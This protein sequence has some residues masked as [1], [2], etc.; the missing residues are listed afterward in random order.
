MSVCCALSFSQNNSENVLRLHLLIILMSSCL[1]LDAP[2]NL[3]ATEVTE[4]TVTV[5]WER[6]QADI[7]G[8]ILSY[9]TAEGSS[10][11]IPVGRDSSSYK[12]VGLKPGV[13]HT[14]YIWSFKGDK[15]SSKSST[16]AETGNPSERP[17]SL[18]EA[19]VNAF[20]HFI[21]QQSD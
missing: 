19:V 11:E 18:R 2:T 7:Q 21:P 3:V 1:D 14:I 10:G 13:L 15:V 6:V 17:W 8:Y 12:M 20:Y 16:K 5:T 4:D 9:T